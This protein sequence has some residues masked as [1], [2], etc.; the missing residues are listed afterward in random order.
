MTKGW[1]HS[2]KGGQIRDRLHST[3][4]PPSDLRFG[5]ASIKH[6]AGV[7]V[8][9]KYC[10]YLL[11]SQVWQ[12]LC[13]VEKDPEKTQD[14]GDESCKEVLRNAPAVHLYLVADTNGPAVACHLFVSRS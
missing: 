12:H 10:K 6:L 3:T 4:P 9:T 7:A 11:S 8:A 5:P 14:D 2:D 1:Q 13:V